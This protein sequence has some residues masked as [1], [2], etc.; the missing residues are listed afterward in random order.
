MKLMGK[1]CSTGLWVMMKA[2]IRPLS[3]IRKCS[4][5]NGVTLIFDVR[6]FLRRFPQSLR[7]WSQFFGLC[8]GQVGTSGHQVVHALHNTGNH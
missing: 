6:N 3:W 7:I 5:L 2:Q 4:P 1:T 8:K